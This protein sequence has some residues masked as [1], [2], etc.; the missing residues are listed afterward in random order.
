MSGTN[1]IS[2]Y[3]PA[4][5]KRQLVLAT[6]HT[7]NLVPHWDYTSVCPHNTHKCQKSNKKC[8]PTLAQP[9]T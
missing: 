5:T 4:A 3:F 6:P 2:L 7:H 1:I 9:N 8:C